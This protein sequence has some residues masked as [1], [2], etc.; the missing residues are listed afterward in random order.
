MVTWLARS[1]H[2]TERFGEAFA[3]DL[4]CGDFLALIG[5]LGSGK[6]A[7]TRGICRGLKC[8]I[9]AHSPSFNLVNYYPGDIEV[10]H[11]DLYRFNGNLE[12]LGWDELPDSKR[13]IIVEWAEK[14]AGNLPDNRYDIFFEITDAESRT[15]RIDEVDDTRN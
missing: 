7:F 13:I 2:E 14:A 5:P 3:R 10:V 6:T 8:R 11:V 9:E 1:E 15:I 4:K 12:E